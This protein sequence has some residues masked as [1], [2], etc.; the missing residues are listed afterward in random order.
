M[1]VTIFIIS[2]VLSI[3]L[4]T[5]GIMVAYR[6]KKKEEYSFVSSLFYYSLLVAFYGIYSIWGHLAFSYLLR[7]VIES[8][9]NLLNISSIFPLMG[10]PVLIVGW[11][12]FIQFSVELV[13]R[14][15][16]AYIAIIY[17]TICLAILLF[18][19]DY[20]KNQLVNQ[21]AIRHFL[22]FK[23]LAIINLAVTSIGGLTI[24][25]IGPEKKLKLSGQVLGLFLIMPALLS[26]VSLF[27]VY[28]HW[29]V[30]V[31]F[32]IFYFSQV[33]LPIAYIYFKVDNIAEA[34]N[35]NFES[36][37]STF[38]ISKRETE[39]ILEICKGK[40]NQAI[41]DSLFITLQ[42]VKDHI[43]H[44]YTKTGAKNR[45]QL[46]NLVRDKIKSEPAKDKP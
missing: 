25:I 42:T 34:A 17:F 32:V 44:I 27:M 29:F 21:E 31:L 37:C 19:G 39:I 10:I 11:Y 45:V 36:F 2:F 20:F 4:A 14:K 1:K 16:H 12:L 13:G 30:P 46:T 18:L 28:S 5:F 24:F 3:G 6:L 9:N 35:E 26:T 40:T 23:S 15:L 8:P 33:A 22:L 43:H 41:A 7:D 38:E